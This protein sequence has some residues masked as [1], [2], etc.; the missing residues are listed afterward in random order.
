VFRAVLSSLAAVGLAL[1]LG[2]A[3]A[4]AKGGK[5][6]DMMLGPGEANVHG[7]GNEALIRKNKWGYVYIAGK[8]DSHIT[9]TYDKATNSLTYADTGTKK[10]LTIPKACDRL[11]VSKGIAA[12]CKVPAA[13][14]SKKFF[15]QVWPRLGNDWLDAHTMSA[16]F[17]VWA[18]MD[19]GKDTVYLGKGNDFVNGAMGPDWIYG[20]KG[21]DLMRTGKGNDHLW[22]GEGRDRLSCA[23]NFD[24]AHWGPGD[25]FYQCEKRIKS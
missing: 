5:H 8:H 19:D 11:K 7:L 3:P 10:L 9:I 14:D 21:N 6:P 22:G 12:V 4:T 18:L 15:V 16:H 23:E 25:S 24:V 2:T 1:T 17:R 20:G 13:F